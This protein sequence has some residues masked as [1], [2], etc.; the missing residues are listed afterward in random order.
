MKKETISF[1]ETGNFSKKFLHFIENNSLSYYPKDDNILNV[2]KSLNFSNDNRELLFKELET[3][4]KNIETS[5]FVSDN[6]KSI[7]SDNTYTVTTGH[8]LNIFTGPM[9]VIYKI[10][11]VIKLSRA[12][13]KKYPKYKFVPIYWMASE[14]HDFEEIKSFHSKG[15]TYT[16]DIKSKGPV[17]NLNTETLKNIFDEDITIPDFLKDA[18]SSS[19]SLS[20]AVRKYM[21]ELFG[22][23]GLVTI[24][25]NSANLKKTI[26]DIVEDDVINNT[27][28]KIEKSSAQAS[29]VYVRKINFFYQGSNFRERIDKSDRYNIL[30]TDIS[31]T[32]QEI[33]DKIRSSPE[34][35]SPN[36]ITRC[37][38]QQ[39]IL[40]NVCYIGGPAEI[41]YWESFK[42]FF[43][44]YK[45]PYPVLVPRDFVLILTN[46]IQKLIN[47]LNL[48]STDLFNNK[49]KIE[50][51]VFAID[52]DKS[53]NFKREINEINKIL[54]NISEK[55]G[56]EDSTMKPHVLA[57][58]KK[59]EKRL[60][61]IERRYIN[62]QKKN[63]DKLI[64]QISDLFMFLNPDN[65]IQ[66][67]KEN[68]IS[69]YDLNFIDNLIENLDPLDLQFK[70][71][72]K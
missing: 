29:D 46:K 54:N 72:K 52:T 35:F 39:K 44:N 34:S 40:P 68:F 51:K 7:L 32:E 20:E 28:E 53:K 69:F 26:T 66:E 6:I 16:W 63:N 4:Y 2:L 37:L 19:S 45:I 57:T 70:I 59:M 49:N 65:S 5:T 60:L 61:Q 41:V 30:S 23:Y 25:P 18:Y 55:F 43:D 9:Y 27:I 33:K 56:K 36:V 13:S 12:L 58:A 3:Q 1:K 50:N 71:L 15:K 67:R 47:K 64:D 17:G 14:D 24:D 31:F 22:E 48:S 38:Y 10:V 21:N 8:Q 11:S 62:K 42:K